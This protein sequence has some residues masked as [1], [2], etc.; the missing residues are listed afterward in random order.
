VAGLPKVGGLGGGLGG[1]GGNSND[2][3]AEGTSTET[4][5]KPP[6]GFGLDNGKDVKGSLKVHISKSVFSSY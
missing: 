6:E 4:K 5:T 1:I 2:D 3:A